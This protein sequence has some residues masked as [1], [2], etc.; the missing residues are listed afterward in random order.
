[1]KQKDHLLTGHVDDDL[2]DIYVELFCD[3][4]FCGDDEHTFHNWW[5]GT[6]KWKE[7]QFSTDLDV[8][9]ARCGLQ[10]DN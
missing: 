6:A 10:I 2:N 1:M 3:A 4:D 5:V 9:K 8:Q 7:H